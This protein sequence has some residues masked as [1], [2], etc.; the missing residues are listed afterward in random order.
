MGTQSS[1]NATNTNITT[2]C[3]SLLAY[4]GRTRIYVNFHVE[5]SFEFKNFP[6]T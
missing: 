3:T 1:L 5:R 2:D 6:F 4:I